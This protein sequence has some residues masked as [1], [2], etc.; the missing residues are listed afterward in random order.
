VPLVLAANTSS[1]S[2]ALQATTIDNSV[3]T[4]QATVTTEYKVTAI[5]Q[6]KFTEGQDWWKTQCSTGDLTW[7]PRS[8]FVDDDGIENDIFK[9]FN[10]QHPHKNT[11][12]STTTTNKQKKRKQSSQGSKAAKKHKTQ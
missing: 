7:E 5:L 9:D 4:T 10:D 2:S 12:K 6:R 8:S 1:T 3:T 11:K